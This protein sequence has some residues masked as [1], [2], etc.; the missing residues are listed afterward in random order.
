MG[1]AFA[2]GAAVQL[3]SSFH[4]VGGG[5]AQAFY[6]GAQL[7]CWTFIIHYGMTLNGLTAALS[8]GPFWGDEQSKANLPPTGGLGRAGK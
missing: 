7:L 5:V 3:L 8:A 4:Y 2:A 1:S 6:V